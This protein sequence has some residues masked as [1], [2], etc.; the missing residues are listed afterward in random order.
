M[1][2]PHPSTL[3]PQAAP[4]LFVEQI[5]DC[6]D[7]SLQASYKWR[8]SEFFL[9]GHFPG[10]PIVPG[11]ILCEMLL[12]CGALW[13]ALNNKDTMAKGT[14]VVTRIQ[15][16]KFKQMV[17][18]NDLTTGSVELVER[19]GDVVYFKGKL[20]VEDKIALTLQFTVA[21]V[22]SKES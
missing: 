7:R 6:S 5:L 15:E 21:Q 13:V 2:F 9:A 8:P 4:F 1:T 14:P 18:P 3:I 10:N 16:A 22:A 12:Q 17:R 11:V 19:L 20:L